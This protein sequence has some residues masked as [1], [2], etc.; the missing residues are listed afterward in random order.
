MNEHIQNRY[1]AKE[2]HK[3]KNKNVTS[4]KKKVRRSNE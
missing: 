2:M 3:I 4:I 1:V